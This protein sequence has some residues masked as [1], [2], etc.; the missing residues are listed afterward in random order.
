[1]LLFPSFKP[2]ILGARM[3]GFGTQIFEL[4]FLLYRTVLGWGV[5]ACFKWTLDIVMAFEILNHR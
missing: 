2:F 4:N 5:F 1:M 3:L